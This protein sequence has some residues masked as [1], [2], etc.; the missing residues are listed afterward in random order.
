MGAHWRER[1][2]TYLCMC[3]W[4]CRARG[5]GHR[6][7][8]VNPPQVVGGSRNPVTFGANPDVGTVATASEGAKRVVLWGNSD[9]D[10]RVDRFNG[11]TTPQDPQPAAVAS[12]DTTSSEDATWGP[13]AAAL[14]NGYALL[15]ATE[16]TS[17]PHG[18]FSSE[19]AVDLRSPTN[20]EVALSGPAVNDVQFCEFGESPTAAVAWNGTQFLLSEHCGTTATLYTVTTGGVVTQRSTLTSVNDV[21]LSR[22]GSGFLATYVVTGTGSDVQGQR[23]DAN[24]VKVGSVLAIAGG[25]GNQRSPAAAPSGTTNLVVWATD[26]SGGNGTDLAARTVS[27]TGAL[28]AVHAL[29]ATG[30]EQVDPTVTG[31]TGGGVARGVDRRARLRHRRHER[32]PG[33]NPR[34]RVRDHRRGRRRIA[35][36]ADPDPRCRT[37]L[38]SS[39]G[40]TPPRAS[41]STSSG[42]SGPTAS[43]SAR[44]HVPPASRSRRPVRTSPVA[45]GSSSPCGR[46]PGWWG[47]RTSSPGA[48]GL[49]A[50]PAGGLINLSAT[51]GD[52]FCPRAA[53]NGSN[54]LVVWTDRRNG[55]TDIFGALVSGTGAVT[56]SSGFAISARA[57]EQQSPEVTWNGTDFVVTWNDLRNGN[58]DIYAARVAP[59]RTVR[60]PNGIAVTTAAG[61]Q[62]MPTVASSG[63]PTLITWVSNA[64]VQRRIMRPTAPSSVAWSRKGRASEAP[65]V[66]PSP[67][68]RRAAWASCSRRTPRASCSRRSIRRT[69]R[70]RV[71]PPC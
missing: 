62:R 14:G 43:P 59:D 44:R 57:S 9:A 26:G 21:A 61:A 64:G 47:T 13:S 40:S 4:A 51:G 32:A 70:R 24:G 22:S 15:A 45:V 8:P 17:G 28:G 54:W 42:R 1:H 58:Q 39:P 69:V 11:A 16:S 67:P 19:E 50:F 36:R 33:R 55:T 25:A 71:A 34:R 65:S 53:W 2:A 48:T 6:V 7:E 41:G 30:G 46:R 56:P 68:H 60:D 5:R 38:R 10:L 52:Q 35:G 29:A 20:Q 66:R 3:F 18:D 31:S 63:G 27:S 37:A 23:L 12:P 49:T